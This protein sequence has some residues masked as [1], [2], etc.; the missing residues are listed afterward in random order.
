MIQWV[1]GGVGICDTV[2][3]GRG[4]YLWYSGFGEGWVFAIQWVWGGVG[5]CDTVGVG[6]GSKCTPNMMQCP[7]RY[8]SLP[9]PQKTV[10]DGC[11]CG[12]LTSVLELTD[13]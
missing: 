9:P 10:T 11:E 1:W 13:Q 4:G 2:G 12:W 8:F 5:I 3:V 6:R 7:G